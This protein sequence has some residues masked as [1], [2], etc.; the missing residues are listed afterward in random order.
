M[1]SKIDRDMQ[2]NPQAGG[3]DEAMQAL[4]DLLLEGDRAE[5]TT[6]ARRV[7]ALAEQ[8]DDDEALIRRVNP[9]LGEAIRRKIR[10]SRE[11]MIETLY[12]II[13]QLVLRAVS[14]A[15]RDLART[16]D[17]RMRRTLS[18]KSMARRIQAQVRGISGADVMLRDALPFAITE[19]FIIHRQTG[20]LLYHTSAEQNDLGQDEAWVDDSDVISGMLTAIQDFVRDAFGDITDPNDDA[21]LDEIQYGD[22]SILLETARHA[23]IA[24]VADGIEPSGFR[25]QLRQCIVGFNL[26]NEDRLTTFDG[27]MAGLDPSERSLSHLLQM[28]PTHP[29][30]PAN[31]D[32]NAGSTRSN[33]SP[34]ARWM[35]VAFIILAVILLAWWIITLL[36]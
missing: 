3:E 14:E 20:I 16:I 34:I 1:N 18:P 15:I 36:R 21:D 24:V 7:D 6:L 32:G 30:Q 17:A 19:I 28:M 8:L 11:E 10:D 2:Q 29:S 5:A 25:T 9:I 22:A 12:P 26:A 33:G 4:R 35:P 31:R 27:N 23:Y 13:G